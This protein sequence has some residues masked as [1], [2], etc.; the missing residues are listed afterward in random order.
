MDG[1]G[2]CRRNIGCRRDSDSGVPWFC[3]D[4]GKIGSMIIEP[5]AALGLADPRHADVVFAHDVGGKEKGSVVGVGI[6]IAEW[7]ELIGGDR[8]I[9]TDAEGVGKDT[10]AFA[11]V[12]SQIVHF[13]GDDTMRSDGHCF[14]RLD[15][16]CY[17]VRPVVDV[18]VRRFLVGIAE[19]ERMVGVFVC[20]EVIDVGAPVL[21]PDIGHGT[22][23]KVTF[24][25]TDGVGGAVT[26][27]VEA[28]EVAKYVAGEGGRI[29]A[30]SAWPPEEAGRIAG[31]FPYFAD[32]LCAFG[33]IAGIDEV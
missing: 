27:V 28:V 22:G 20:N 12:V 2:I 25:A 3:R 31:L 32:T 18:D 1:S 15:G 5:I 14:V 7:A 26:V 19:D 9:G 21:A 23:G 29:D 30:A 33:G 10:G 17:G 11:H 13:D 4:D 24:R 8:N 6:R 16:G